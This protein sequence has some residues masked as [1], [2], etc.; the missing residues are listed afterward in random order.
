MSHKGQAHHAKLKK[1]SSASEPA[2]K[3]LTSK[4][5]QIKQKDTGDTGSTSTMLS[6]DH[7]TTPTSER[8]HHQHMMHQSQHTPMTT[9]SHTCSQ[10]QQ[11]VSFV[12]SRWLMEKGPT[13]NV[14]DRLLMG[15]CGNQHQKDLVDFDF[16]GAHVEDR[17]G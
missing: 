16:E 12:M 15:T 3:D 9:T 8:Q 5:S 11:E 17:F 14:P 10:S 1:D 2:Y 13:S 6:L 4:S 7:M